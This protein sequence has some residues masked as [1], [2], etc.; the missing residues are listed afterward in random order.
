M[1]F[2]RYFIEIRPPRALRRDLQTQCG[3][4]WDGERL[5][6]PPW[7]WAHFKFTRINTTPTILRKKIED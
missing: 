3:G 7:W 5:A 1:Q 2:H 4:L 6:I